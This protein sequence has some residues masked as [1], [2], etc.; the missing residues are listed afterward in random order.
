[1]SYTPPLGNA[2]NVSWLGA[3]VYAPPAGDAGDVSFAIAV[4]GIGAGVLPFLAEASGFVGGTV[5]GTGDG[6]LPFAAAG[7]GAHAVGGPAAG[8][9]GF[10]AAGIGAHGVQGAGAAPMPFAAAGVALH[11]RYEARGVVKLGG[12]LVNRRVRVYD[13]LTGAFLSQGDTVAGKFG[14]HA[15]FAESEVYAIPID[16]SDGAVDWRP[17]VANRVRTVLAQDAT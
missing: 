11:P 13:R 10:S 16:L 12:V 6:V 17:P 14:V 15:G 7:V 3:P 2:G 8:V 4:S 5:T 1:M 9:L